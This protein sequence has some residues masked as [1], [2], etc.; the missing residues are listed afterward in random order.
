MIQKKE[1]D[2]FDKEAIELCHKIITGFIKNFDKYKLSPEN[3]ISLSKALL[4]LNKYPAESIWG[5]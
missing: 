3:I 5:H 2:F 1:L 4:A